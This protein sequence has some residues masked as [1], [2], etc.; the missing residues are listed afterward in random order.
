MKKLIIFLFAASLAVN[1]SAQAQND[2]VTVEISFDANETF[3]TYE[4]AWEEGMTAM[5]ALQHCATI[6]TTPVKDYIF[7]SDIDGTKNIPYEKAWY[8]Q[9]NG[10]STRL[11]AYR[12]AIQKGDKIRWIYKTDV[13]SATKH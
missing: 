3:N 2:R 5:T 13:C 9:V 8:Y 12:Q 4:V 1:A 7:V 6:V 11:L 10:Q